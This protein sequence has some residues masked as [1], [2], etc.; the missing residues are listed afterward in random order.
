[1]LRNSVASNGQFFL[2]SL[3]PFAYCITTSV[4]GLD[5]LTVL[6]CSSRL[7]HATF[8]S[9]TSGLHH[10]R[11]LVLLDCSACKRSDFESHS[12]SIESYD[13]LKSFFIINNLSYWILLVNA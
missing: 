1:M 4:F 8:Y 10:F 12:W 11:S 7:E 6:K 2:H 13:G 3:I 5:T 9:G